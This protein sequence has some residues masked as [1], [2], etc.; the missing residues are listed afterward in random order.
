MHLDEPGETAF[1]GKLFSVFM[2]PMTRALAVF[3][4]LFVAA[5]VPSRL[6]DG[7]GYR[8]AATSDCPSPYTCIQKVCARARSAGR[9]G[10]TQ[11]TYVVVATSGVACS[12]DDPDFNAGLGASKACRMKDTALLAANQFPDAALL[13]GDLQRGDGSKAAFDAS[14]AL[15]WGQ[16][17]LRALTH[18]VPG[19][20]EYARAGA[21]GFFATF[22][23]VPP[24]TGYYSFD[25]GAWHLIALN[26]ACAQVGGCD[27][28]SPQGK[29]L[30]ADLAAHPTACVLAYF[31]AP[32]FTSASPDFAVKPFWDALFAHHADVVLSGGDPHYERFDPLDSTGNEN[33]TAGVRSFIIGIGGARIGN[34]TVPAAHSNKL[35]VTFGVLRLQ[36]AAGKYAWS[37]QA[38]DDQPLSDS[39]SATCHAS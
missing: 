23:E 26:S 28:S 11:D 5:C 36:L 37:I 31:Y 12:P 19:A 18:P 22:P 3:A 17:P 8:C 1:I 32:L 38:V 39:G 6:G 30:E 15:A 13:V 33:P 10:G 9:D 27:A 29:W 21:P 20:A 7:E 4:L 25:L 34:T 24:G 14:Y 35:N 2:V 16:T